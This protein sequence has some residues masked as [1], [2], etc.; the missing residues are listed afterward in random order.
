MSDPDGYVVYVIDKDDPEPEG[1][2][3]VRSAFPRCGNLNGREAVMGEVLTMIQLCNTLCAG[4]CVKI[5]TDTALLGTDWLPT[6]GFAG[7]HSCNGYYCTGCCYGLTM[8]CLLAMWDYVMS[9]NIGDNRY[10]LPED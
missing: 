7:F 2:Y 1:C 3:F 6:D 4:R 10:T 5:D 9:H 8:T